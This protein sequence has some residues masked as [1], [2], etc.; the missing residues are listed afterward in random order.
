MEVLGRRRTWRTMCF[1]NGGCGEEVFAHTNGYGDFVL[2]DRLGW[3]WEIH[4]CYL[5]RF[6]L[7]IGSAPNRYEIRA[8]ALVEYRDAY[9]KVPLVVRQKT[10]KDIRR[11]NANDCVGEPQKLLLGY[12]QDYIENR[13]EHYLRGLGTIGQQHLRAALGNNR[14]Q[15]T[16]IT[17]DLESYT[18]YADLRNVVI[19][20]KD[21]VA[22]R[23]KAARVLGISGTNAV[24][25]CDEILLVRGSP[26]S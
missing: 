10:T 17:S 3:P 4:N 26:S 14:S 23:M 13:A 7:Q 1:I 22:A 25:I 24:F 20:K 19:R 8:S 5:N 12:V 16:I 18:A 9:Q 6:C 11:V 21:M 2:F 15:I